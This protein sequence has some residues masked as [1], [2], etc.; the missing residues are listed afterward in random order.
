VQIIEEV[1]LVVLLERVF[2]TL[3][4]FFDL[5]VGQVDFLVWVYVERGAGTNFLNLAFS[6][7]PVPVVVFLTPASLV[8]VELDVQL[9]G[10]AFFK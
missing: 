10:C 3:K 7:Q 5:L 4:I 6:R 9:L 8:E 2:G 1:L